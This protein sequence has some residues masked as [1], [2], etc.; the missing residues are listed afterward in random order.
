MTPQELP[1]GDWQVLLWSPEGDAFHI[2]TVT[3]MVA[4]NRQLFMDRERVDYIVLGLASTREELD[5]IGA[6][7]MKVRNARS[8]L[9]KRRPAD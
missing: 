9:G 6:P 3:E 4:K 2:E 8:D 5:E 1:F 7:Y